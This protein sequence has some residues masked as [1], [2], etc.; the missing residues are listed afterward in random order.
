L[1]SAHGKG[2]SA[3]TLVRLPELVVQCLGATAVYLKTFRLDRVLELAHNLTRFVARGREM[4]LPATTLRNLE[5]FRPGGDDGAPITQSGGI[6]APGSL[7]WVLRHTVTSMGGRLLAGWLSHPLTNAE[8]VALRLFNAVF[9]QKL[10][11]CLFCAEKSTRGWVQWPSWRG[12][13][14]TQAHMQSSNMNVY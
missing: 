9:S 12:W 11:L 7:L 13:L 14:A 8:Y 6:G 1:A 5:I 2:G 3:E 4:L 10:Y